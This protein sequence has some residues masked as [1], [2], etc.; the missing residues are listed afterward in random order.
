MMNGSNKNRTVVHTKDCGISSY[1]NLQGMLQDCISQQSHEL[2]VSI[3]I[4]EERNNQADKW[5]VKTPICNDIADKESIS[6]YGIL[7]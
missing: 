1:N 2:C 5:T 3:I 4:Q 7:E 6:E